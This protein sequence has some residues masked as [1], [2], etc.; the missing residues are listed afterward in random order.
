MQLMFF[1]GLFAI[2]ELDLIERKLNDFATKS[3]DI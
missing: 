2:I 3:N 1:S